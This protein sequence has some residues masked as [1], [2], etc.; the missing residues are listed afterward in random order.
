M[1]PLSSVRAAWAWGNSAAN[2]GQVSG[3]AGSSGRA[4]SI[5]AAVASRQA[6]ASSAG[7]WSAVKTKAG[8]R[9]LPLLGLARH[10]LA[11]RK[12]QQ[13][14]DRVKLGSAWADTGL[15]FTTRTGRPIEPRNLVRSFVRVRDTHGIRKIRHTTASLLKDLKVPPRDAQIIL[16]HA[17]ISTTQ[18]IY[19]HVDKAAR[20]KA[21]TRLNKLLGARNEPLLWS[22]LVVNRRYQDLGRVV[23]AGGA[24]GSRTPDPLLANRWQDVHRRPSPQVT[25]LKRAPASVQIR[26]GCCT[27]PLYSPAGSAAARERCSTVRRTPGSFL[28]R[29]W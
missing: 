14:A 17:H 7:I 26:V 19:I 18:Q 11:A 27:F 15:V 5:T 22:A 3:A 4:A 8:S 25:V 9:D 10:A 23:F 2:T 24:G 13:E 1:P 16:G 28:R 12:K 21:L 6:A 20:R 29:A